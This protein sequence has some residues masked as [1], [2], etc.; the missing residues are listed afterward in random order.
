MWKNQYSEMPAYKMGEINCKSYTQYGLL[1]KTIYKE[2]L[3]LDS[4]KP[5]N[6]ILKEANDLKI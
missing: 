6:S 1:S 4:M 2:L 3:Q 5:S